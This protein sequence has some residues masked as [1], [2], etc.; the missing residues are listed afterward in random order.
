MIVKV[1]LIRDKLDSKNSH[2]CL[3]SVR[4]YSWMHAALLV[5]KLYEEVAEVADGMDDLSEYADV[6]QTLMD[7]ARLNNL[8]WQDVLDTRINKFHEH[9]GF[10]D[11]KVVVKDVG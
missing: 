7:L 9:G 6:L 2:I 3:K 11:G 8:A 1:K 4:Q 10:S 5:S